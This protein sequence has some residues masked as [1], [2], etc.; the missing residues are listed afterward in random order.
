MIL[1]EEIL[2]D[3]LRDAAFAGGYEISIEQRWSG[4]NFL[5]IFLKLL[6]PYIKDETPAAEI[7]A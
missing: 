6:K 7:Q 5:T 3:L 2:G 1:N 4:G